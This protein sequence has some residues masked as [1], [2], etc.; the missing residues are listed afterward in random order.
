M[1][2]TNYLFS[3]G[4]KL[5]LKDNNGLFYRDSKVKITDILDGT[6]NTVMTGETL[7][8]DG[9]AGGD[10]RRHHV[11][12][13]SAALAQADEETG[14]NDFKSGKNVVGTRGRSW[15]DGRF[16]QGTF[17]GT[18]SA[19]DD[20]PD[21]D[22]GGDGGLSGLRSLGN[23]VQV[24]FGDGSVRAISLGLKLDTWKLLTDRGDGQVIP[25]F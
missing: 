3:A 1:G 14:V 13:K 21:V 23:V 4:S 25:E 10:V 11:Q 12:L 9:K 18:R 6:S 2:P 19:N 15:M 17:T 16:L 22:C 20:K 5:G 8:G 7:K 24:G